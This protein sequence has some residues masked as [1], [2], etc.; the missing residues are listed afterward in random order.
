[1]SGR[2]ELPAVHGNRVVIE[3][4]VAGRYVTLEG[5]AQYDCGELR[6]PIQDLEGEFTLVLNESTWQG[7]ISDAPDRN[8]FLIRIW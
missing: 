3:L 4:E 8:G 6:V 5:I 1:M 7:E 2:Y